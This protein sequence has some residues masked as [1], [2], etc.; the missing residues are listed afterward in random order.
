M[1]FKIL[2]N[3]LQRPF[4]HFSI[5]ELQS[6]AIFSFVTYIWY[7]LSYFTLEIFSKN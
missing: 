1:M 7:Q 3:Y 6:E 2:K 4:S 5:L